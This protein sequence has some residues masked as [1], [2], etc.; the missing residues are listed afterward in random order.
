MYSNNQKNGEGVF[1]YASGD[2][3][4]GTFRNDL[5]HGSGD[6]TSGGYYE[7]EWKDDRY[8]NVGTLCYPNGD[9]YTG[10]FKDGVM[11]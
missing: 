3:Y 6:F 8:H 7:G 2:Q 9:V 4:R 11:E 10:G 5:R 1:R